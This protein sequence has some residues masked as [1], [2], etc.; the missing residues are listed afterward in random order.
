MPPV[1]ARRVLAA[2]TPANGPR[3]RP[4]HASFVAD[5]TLGLS[6]RMPGRV[7]V[8][9]A[10]YK[11]DLAAPVG[12]SRPADGVPGMPHSAW[13]KLRDWGRFPAGQAR[14]S[15]DRQLGMATGSPSVAWGPTGRPWTGVCSRLKPPPE[16]GALVDSF[17]LRRVALSVGRATFHPR[18]R[19]PTCCRSP[20]GSRMVRRSSGVCGLCGSR[21][22]RSA[23]RRVPVGP[24][25][26]RLRRPRRRRGKPPGGRAP[27][28]VCKD[29]GCIPS[30]H[31]GQVEPWCRPLAK[32]CR[33]DRGQRE[34]DCSARLL[35][36]ACDCREQVA[37]AR[38]VT[39]SH[40]RWPARRLDDS[41]SKQVV[42]EA[43]H[44]SSMVGRRCCRRG[45]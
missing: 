30:G 45:A 4:G 43:E 28:L 15:W 17:G 3:I 44:L 12:P 2:P 23:P 24:P 10:R 22:M 26:H 11:M 9:P 21:P 16:A 8:P 31:L 39:V 14:F 36:R 32:T 20:V 40:A 27:S 5:T 7:W 6:G 38:F 37:A 41:P 35:A 34:R 13:G 33:G 19:G 25:P 42:R 1:R 18:A 29:V